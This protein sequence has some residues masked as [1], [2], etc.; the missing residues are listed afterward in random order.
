MIL[1]SGATESMNLVAHTFGRSRIGA[2]DEVLVSGM[3]HHSN[4]VPWQMLCAEVGEIGRAS[5]RERV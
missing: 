1:T 2:G 3:E 4:I 5:C